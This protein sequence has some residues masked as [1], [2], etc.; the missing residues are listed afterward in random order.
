MKKIIGKIQKNW[1]KLK[2]ENALLSNQEGQSAVEMAIMLPVLLFILFAIVNI[3]LY[4]HAHL[5]VA[6]AAQQGVRIGALT[7]ENSKINGAINNSLQNL[8]D[9]TS[10]TNVLIE[11]PSE[12]GRHRGDDLKVTVIYSYPMPIRFKMPFGI[13]DNFFDQDSLQIKSV[14][15]SRIEYE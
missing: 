11:P 8:R 7:N 12:S 9:Y 6:F 15:V 4:M 10:R 13:T 2:S 5:E 1:R 14:A 3:G